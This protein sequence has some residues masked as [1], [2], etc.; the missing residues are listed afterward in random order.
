MQRECCASRRANGR[1]Y[2]R[3]SRAHALGCHSPHGGSQLVMED[4]MRKAILSRYRLL[5]L[6]LLVIAPIVLAFNIHV[7][8]A[9][10]N[11]A[12]PR[13]TGYEI[14]WYSVDDGG[15]MNLSGG[16]YTLSGTIGQPDA[17]TLGGGT[18]TLNGGFWFDIFGY[19]IDLP[20]IVR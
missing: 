18:Y 10:P 11:D 6:T 16:S 19:R 17:G 3:G 14:S 1:G 2:Q 8:Y 9:S 20:I 12:A 15:A 4:V 13:T 5:A 7:T